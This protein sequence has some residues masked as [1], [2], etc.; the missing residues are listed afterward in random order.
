MLEY[1]I[2]VIKAIIWMTIESL[3]ATTCISSF[4]VVQIGI[5]YIW[6]CDAPFGNLHFLLGYELVLSF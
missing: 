1:K 2:G 5:S 3:M 6:K 4:E